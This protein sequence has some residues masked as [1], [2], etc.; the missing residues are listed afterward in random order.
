MV[1]E[2]ALRAH[3]DLQKLEAEK[4]RQQET[5]LLQEAQVLYH[6]IQHHITS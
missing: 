1:R 6:Y 4:K 5:L 2:Q 3:D